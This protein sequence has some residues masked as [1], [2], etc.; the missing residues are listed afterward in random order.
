M[1]S[2]NLKTYILMLSLTV[3]LV[4]LSA[5]PTIAVSI[6]CSTITA[7]ILSYSITKFSPKYIVFHGCLILVLN[8][9]FLGNLFGAIMTALPVLLCGLVMGICYNLKI[10]TAKLLCSSTAVHVISFVIN[11]KCIKTTAS[12]KTIFEDAIAFLGQTYKESLMAITSTNLSPDELNHIVSE[13]TSTLLVLSPGFIVIACGLVA[14][15][16]YFAFCRILSIQHENTENLNA[17]STWKAEKSICIIYFII[18]VLYFISPVDTW[19]SNISLNMIMV[20]TVVF[21]IFGL[22]FTE[23]KLKNRFSS[24]I[25]RRLILLVISFCSITFTGIPF[26]V[27][28]T[29]GVFD[30]FFD[31]RHRKKH[32]G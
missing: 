9:L 25:L 24:V 4:A 26:F 16:S 1:S 11:I 2:R 7:A 12:G 22:S 30:G 31:Y 32:I 18:A 20:M 13:L 19:V 29:I 15:I 8:I 28:S 21:F 6:L 27:L 3:V 17:F 14:F 10:P 5:I 23:Y